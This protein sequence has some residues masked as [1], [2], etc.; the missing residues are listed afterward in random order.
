MAVARKAAGGMRYA[1][2][3]PLTAL[4]AVI[5]ATNLPVS[6][7][8]SA[9]E[10]TFAPRAPETTK[11]PD[12][13]KS[14]DTS[15]SPEAPRRQELQGIESAME[16]SAFE[17]RRLGYEIDNL[18]LEAEKLRASLIEAARRVRQAE[19]RL[20]AE[21]ARLADLNRREGALRLS[22]QSRERVTVEI[23]AAMQRIGR[24]PPPA[25]LVSPED[26]LSAMRAAI[27]LGAIVPD[28]RDEAMILVADLKTLAELRRQ[29]L[30]S[31]EVLRRERD[32]IAEDRIRMASLVETR[33]AQ[34]TL[35]RDQLDREK[36]RVAALARDAKS[37][38]DLISKS[39]SEI[40]GNAR[41][42]EIA[43]RAPLPAKP[44]TAMASL[45]PGAAGI[46]RLQPRQLFA[47]RRGEIALPVSGQVI[48][49]FGEADGLGGS[50]RGITISSQPGAVVVAPADGWVH[51]AAPYRGY[52]HLL[53]INGGG[54]Y[55][56]VLAGMGRLSVEIGQFVLA[57]EPVGFLG[58]A[59]EGAQPD[60]AAGGKVEGA[61][62][63]HTGVMPLGAFRPALY[64]EFRKDGSPV[65]PSPWW[66][67]QTAEKAR[68]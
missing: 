40:V 14:P 17:Q 38:R 7:R 52:G 3:T 19:E 16:K 68:G 20:D 50:E 18:S 32:G 9:Q 35:S 64:V 67:S 15:K 21:E 27:L 43:R 6:Q 13:A 37:L 25:L 26:V 53:I 48:R 31:T 66:S 22:L 24:K 60:I 8:V 39:E 57:G 28:M 61:P 4:V 58:S 29:T 47:E 11:S 33:Q 5:M 1:H 46:G 23:L 2:A 55:H 49:Q 34:I 36:T 41:A 59:R 62:S 54:G 65:D 10:G 45:Q 30:A 44:G 56:I 12:A 42:A 51:F 63:G